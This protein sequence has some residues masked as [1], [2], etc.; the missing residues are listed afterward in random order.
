MTIDEFA[1]L[2]DLEMEVMERPSS[3]VKNPEMRYFASFKRV[4]VMSDGTLHGAFGDG[5]TPRE[6]IA[7]YADRISGQRLAFGAYT[8]ARREFEA[9]NEFLESEESS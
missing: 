8:D 1:E 2:H 3:L 6:A 9:P 5:E 4:E 7:D